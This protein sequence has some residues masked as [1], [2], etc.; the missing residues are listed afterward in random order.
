[1]L[2]KGVYPYEYM[3]DWQNFNEITLHKKWYSN[4]N[5]DDFSDADYFIAKKV[6]KDFEMNSL[7]EYHGLYFKNDTLILTD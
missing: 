6:C 4:L 3:D 2:R 5:M 1:M 7:G